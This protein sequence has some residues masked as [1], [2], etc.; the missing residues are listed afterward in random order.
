MYDDVRGGSRFGTRSDRSRRAV[1]ASLTTAALL[2]LAAAPAIAAV[3]FTKVQYESP[4]PDTGSNK[5]LNAEFVVIKNKGSRPKRLRGWKLVDKRTKAEGGNKVFRFPRLRLGPGKTVKIHT[6]KGRRTRTDLY[7]GQSNYVW[8][9]DADTAYLYKK[10][11]KLADRCH[12][13]SST[14]ETSPPA[15]C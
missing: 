3:R 2:L 5:S 1:V 12:Y 4:G 6:G 15:S 14:K 9:D 11:G 7:W 8:G 13:V 10:S